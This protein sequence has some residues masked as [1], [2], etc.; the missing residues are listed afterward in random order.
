[1]LGQA[2]ASGRDC[3]DAIRTEQL[4]DFL[5]LARIMRGHDKLLIAQA[6]SRQTPDARLGEFDRVSGGIAT[7]D[8]A[9]AARPFEIRFDGNAML[10]EL[11]TPDV[12]LFRARREADMT[13]AMGAMGRRRGEGFWLHLG[14]ERIEDEQHALTAM[15]KDE[16]L[17]ELATHSEPEDRLIE[18]AQRLDILAIDDGFEDGFR[19]HCTSCF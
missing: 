19:L 7:I 6:S 4:V 5:D 13:R 17:F 1:R 2:Q 16:L 3:L 11:L 18:M 10:L 8:G 12:E 14:F 9:P 15:E